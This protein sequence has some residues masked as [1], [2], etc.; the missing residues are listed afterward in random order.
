MLMELGHCS[1]LQALHLLIGFTK[2]YTKEKKH[3]NPAS[4]QP[5]DRDRLRSLGERKSGPED[6]ITNPKSL[7]GDFERFQT[8]IQKFQRNISQCEEKHDM[9]HKLTGKT[10]GQKRWHFDQTYDNCV[11]VENTEK[12]EEPKENTE[13]F[14]EMDTL[15]NDDFDNEDDCV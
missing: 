9:L 14:D 15:E 13:N 10:S 5:G 4:K 7:Q 1:P 2:L 12:A 6:E 8:N 11:T 3:R